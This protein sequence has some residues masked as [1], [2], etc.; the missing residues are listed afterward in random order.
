MK[1]ELND[2]QARNGAWDK[3]KGA[4]KEL[5]ARGIIV[6]YLPESEPGK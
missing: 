2:I 3:L 4:E 1:R 5:K 6:R